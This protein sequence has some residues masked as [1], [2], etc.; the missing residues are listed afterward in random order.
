MDELGLRE[1]RARLGIDVVRN[2]MRTEVGDRFGP[3]EGGALARREERGLA[4]D[5]DGVDAL[6]G[7]AIGARILAVHVDAEGAAVGVRGAQLDEL[8]EGRLEAGA[9][10]VTMF[11]NNRNLRVDIET[12]KPILYGPTATTGPWAKAQTRRWLSEI[13]PNAGDMGIMGGR[14]ASTWGDAVEFMMCGASAVQYCSPLIVRGTHYV[15]ELIAGLS[16]Y[17]ER[18]GYKD[19]ARIQGAALKYI[20]KN[21]DLIDK[22]KALYA[23]VDLHKCVGCSRCTDVCCYDAIKFARKAIIKK[24]NCAGCSL[25]TQVCASHAI[26]MHER[27]N[28]EDHFRAMFSAHPDLAPKDFFDMEEENYFPLP[29]QVVAGQTAEEQSCTSC[30]NAND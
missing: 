21:Q 19:V 6:L 5:R 11:A 10:G 25:C 29:E 24:E 20:Y 30:A 26:S 18:R 2:P 7:L 4:P 12:G 3:G 13:A 27:D 9:A 14:G 1:V 28:D 16:H 17:L 15:Q 23:E 22:V 8:V